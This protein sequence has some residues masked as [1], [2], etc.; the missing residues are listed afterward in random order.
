MILPT[1]IPE[2]ARLAD[3]N[4]KTIINPPA[5]AVSHVFRYDYA[6]AVFIIFTLADA[7]LDLRFVANETQTTLTVNTYSVPITSASPAVPVQ[8]F[9][10]LYNFGLIER[11][12]QDYFVGTGL[13]VKPP[14]EADPDRE[15]WTPDTGV[16]PFFTAFEAALFQKHIPRVACFLRGIKPRRAHN[17]HGVLD[18]NGIL[19]NNL[20]A[21]TFT[22]EVITP[23]SYAT[24]NNLRSKV[25]ATG[26]M[27][28][29]MVLD[30]LTRI[31][32]NAYSNFHQIYGCVLQDQSTEVHI[33]KGFYGSQSGYD[34]IFGV[35]ETVISS[36][37]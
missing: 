5:T 31:G 10:Q 7:S 15:D 11:A 36:I 20:W 24:H 23:P 16:T 27:I 37:T 8:N 29:P 22:L 21:A 17:G 28:C 9:S 1:I 33:E 6:S 26:E 30:P 14:D 19:R 32:A 35:P 25:L 3:L 12:V 13:F 34:I 18:A 4:A 2:A